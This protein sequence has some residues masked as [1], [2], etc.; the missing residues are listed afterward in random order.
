M[1]EVVLGWH[2]VLHVR[3]FHTD[4]NLLNDLDALLAW[5]GVQSR[6]LR[7]G[8]SWNRRL[9]S[10]IFGFT[11]IPVQHRDWTFMKHLVMR[12]SAHRSVPVIIT[13]CDAFRVSAILLDAFTWDLAL[14]NSRGHM[15]LS[16][17]RTL[18]SF[19]CPLSG[20]LFLYLAVDQM[21][22]PVIL[23]LKFGW[24]K[25]F[26]LSN[27]LK[28]LVIVRSSSVGRDDCPFKVRVFEIHSLVILHRLLTLSFTL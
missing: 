6:Q 3:C 4:R 15:R 11:R 26:G 17:K 2:F 13:A 28:L 27:H 7:S 22:D 5:H 8:A 10:S 16:A 20:H 1:I 19:N 12:K 25:A 9:T 24:I 21:V 18:V 23:E 14:I